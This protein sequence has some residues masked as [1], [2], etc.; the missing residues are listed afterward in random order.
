MPR[1]LRV[2][3]SV[4][5]IVCAMNLSIYSQEVEPAVVYGKVLQGE[6]Y[7]YTF[8]VNGPA[9]IVEDRNTNI[10]GSLELDE[11][12]LNFVF[13]LVYET[14]DDFVGE[15]RILLRRAAI[16]GGNDIFT[17]VVVQVVPSMLEAKRDIIVLPP[18]QDE[19]SIDVLWNDITG[20]GNS[21]LV[22]IDL[23][24]DGSASITGDK[25]QFSKAIGFE[26]ETSFNYT[27]Q[28]ESGYM[29]SS[30]V[31]VI[32]GDPVE[33][34]NSVLNYL[35]SA[36]SP[37]D[38]FL[39]DPT[40]ELAEG[41]DVFFGDLDAS[42]A[43]VIRYVPNQAS[44]GQEAFTL[45]ND[46]GDEIQVTIDIVDDGLSSLAVRDDKYFTTVSTPI[47]FD[48]RDNDYDQNGVLIDYSDELTI[49]GDGALTFTPPTGYSGV[50][51]FSY[52]ILQGAK[53]I[54]GIIEI[55]VSNYM[56]Q[57]DEYDFQ[58]TEGEAFLI[59][60]L[61]PISN[62]SWNMVTPPSNGMLEFNRGSHV[63][64]CGVAS[65]KRMTIYTPTTGFVGN[66][67]FVLE[68]CINDGPCKE[69]AVNMS[70][71]P[72]DGDCGCRGSDC[73]WPGDA[74]NDG[75]V[76][77]SDILSIGYNY[78][79]IGTARTS[80][81]DEWSS[82]HAEDWSFDQE[83]SE[84]LNN[85]YADSN[86]DGIINSDDADAL[87]I[88]LD[89]YNN[90]TAD[91]VNP[92]KDIPLI[93][94]ETSS[95]PYEAG[96]VATLDV[97][98]G[99][100]ERPAIDVKGVVFATQ[101]PTDKV[102]PNSI[103][104]TLDESWIGAGSTILSA[105][106]SQNGLLEVGISRTS[107]RGVFGGDR[108]GETRLVIR[109]ELDGWIPGEDDAIITFTAATFKNSEGK[110]FDIQGQKLVLDLVNR[111]ENLEVSGPEI[112]IYP[113]PSEGQLTFHA[114][115]QDILQSIELYDMTGKLVSQYVDI[116]EQSYRLDH[117][118][119][120]GVYTARVTS[121]RGVAVEKVQVVESR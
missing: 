9:Y 3:P 80:S 91:E 84:D 52:T 88:H 25:I 79:E 108:I 106:S 55:Y 63:Y 54:T 42:E 16:L 83:G 30:I 116:N 93:F 31:T 71:L 6:T 40:Y 117:Q 22:D 82:N 27:I 75:K 58:T 4:L 90:I 78:G 86:G 50:R 51:E 97:Y 115:K 10:G 61:A 95:G 99:T 36:V 101:F 70:V 18:D 57:R 26:G 38:I 34:A 66:D 94:V 119:D 76:S 48:P 74:N 59:E 111:D 20:T 5:A 110:S 49:D 96:D 37:V 7:E 60:Y 14:E 109:E 73:V 81:D 8:E 112:I 33:Q 21:T 100:T 121:D 120:Q 64:A 92:L 19:V 69:V 102:D 72:L 32:I 114:N 113:N 118:L 89:N 62:Y 105:T 39:I 45:T 41:S 13:K 12:S 23:V 17:E 28:D 46:N 47:T 98:L 87:Y 44:K 67:R 53:E 15:S 85:K 103:K 56:P 43:H 1:F 35:T 77:V 29:S 2:F 24:S 107:D 104:F 11:V 68:Y 65:G